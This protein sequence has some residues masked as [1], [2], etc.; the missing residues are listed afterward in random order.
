VT[1]HLLIFWIQLLVLLSAAHALGALARRFGQ[2]PVVGALGE[3]R[4]CR[5][6]RPRRGRG[7]RPRLRVRRATVA[8]RLRAARGDATGRRR[9]RR[10]VATS[11]LIVL[12]AGACTQVRGLEAIFGT[13]IGSRIA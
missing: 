7:A 9:L 2:P 5:G 8:R 13:F 3:L 12:L 6:R 4:T 1:D 11:P 10:A